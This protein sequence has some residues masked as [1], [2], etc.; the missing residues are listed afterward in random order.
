MPTVDGLRRRVDKLQQE[1]GAG[2]G[3]PVDVTVHHVHAGGVTIM[4]PAEWEQY[5]REHSDDE[6]ITVREIV[7][8]A[9]S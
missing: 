4:T 5:R 6:F 3:E 2:G 1:A 9:N 7:D 8:C